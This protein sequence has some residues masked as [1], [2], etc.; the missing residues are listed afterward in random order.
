M[1]SVFLR[2]GLAVAIALASLSLATYSRAEQAAKVARV[3]ISDAGIY[4]AV[5]VQRVL[6]PTLAGGDWAVQ[7][8]EV[9][10][11]QTTVIPAQPGLCFGI[12]Y[13]ILGAPLGARVN[14][15]IVDRFPGKGLADPTKRALLQ[16]DSQ[17]V[18]RFVGQ[19]S[20]HGYRFENPW[21][22]APGPW[23]FE[24]WAGGRRLATQ[25]FDIVPQQSAPHQKKK[26]PDCDRGHHA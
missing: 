1:G 4:T 3:V 15:T 19:R 25:T 9:V 14:I 12:H 18:E 23:T 22:L 8:N 10:V 17:V 21:E 20:Y 13:T 7:E 2:H 16:A 24:I 11:Q 5:V 6:D 26:L